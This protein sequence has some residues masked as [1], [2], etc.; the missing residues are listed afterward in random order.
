MKICVAQIQS[1]KGNIPV[2]IKNHLNQIKCAIDL[3]A[4]IIVF[5]ELSIINYEPESAKKYATNIKHSIF[6]PF[7]ALANKGKI[8]IGEG[9]PTLA[10]D[11]INIS[12]LIFS[13]NKERTIYSKT[14]LYDDELPF[15]VCG[16][17]QPFLTIKGQKIAL[18]IC[19][20]TL[21]EEHFL[22]AKENNATIYIASVAKSKKGTDKAYAYFSTMAKQYSTPILMANAVGYCD[23]FVSNGH[24][25]I[26]NKNGE[27]VGQ[28]NEQH[29]G[30]LI[31]DTISNS[32]EIHQP[33]IE[34]GQLSDLE[35]IFQL[36]SKGRKHLNN[37]G[38]YQWI[39]TYPTL[40]IIENDLKNKELYVL[41]SN[42]KIIGAICLSHQQE[43]AYQ[44]INWQFNNI[45]ALVIHRL[46]VHPKQLGKGYAS[47]IM[48]F[49][50]DFAKKQLCNT[51]RLDVFS[52][53]LKAI[54]LYQNRD[55]ITRG[56]IH[57][58]GREEAFYA[59]EKEI[60]I[61]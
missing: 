19:Y 12:M 9:M 29:Q 30:L 39:K 47:I 26:W 28:L 32:A 53:N 23:N 42:T 14:L 48:N 57:F 13:P 16:K 10:D 59:M 18:G 35:A 60:L 58:P 11:G 37:N 25:A 55:Y 54:K 7:E 56:N 34:I 22:K 2:N 15:F 36:Y 4:D 38:I 1:L 41:K 52:K 49:A 8:T 21:Q 46:V 43:E 3:N 31:Y 20:E 17:N 27:C 5:P 33:I 6:K 61:D 40:A 45:K 24:S 44:T 51:I 50:E